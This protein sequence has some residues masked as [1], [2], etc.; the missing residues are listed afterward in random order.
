M[1]TRTVVTCSSCSRELPLLPAFSP[2]EEFR[3]WLGNV[4]LACGRSYC[5]ACISA[6]GPT[7]CPSCGE[8][9]QAA[10]LDSLRRAGVVV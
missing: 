6:D 3:L 4:C 8:P 1:A 10:Q 9:T 2:G 5:S 7:P